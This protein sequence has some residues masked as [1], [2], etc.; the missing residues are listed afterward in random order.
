MPPGSHSNDLIV[1][2]DLGTTNSI[3]ALYQNGN[4][5]FFRDKS[6][7]NNAITVPSIINYSNAKP[8]VGGLAFT[9]EPSHNVYSIKRLMGKGR[10]DT[11]ALAKF[12]VADNTEEEGL[13]IL[14]N[15]IPKTPT[16]ISADILKYLKT[17]AENELGMKVN[18]AVITVPAYFDESARQATKDAAMIA[19]LQVIRLLSEPTAA[20]Y[21]YRLDSRAEGIYAV[22]DLGGGTFDISILRMYHGVLQ[23]I[24]V[25]GDPNLGGDDLDN[26]LM[27][28][29]LSKHEIQP[30]V[31]ITELNKILLE[32]RA[33]KEE[34]TD[35]HEVS[36]AFH[37]IGIII[38]RNELNET[39]KH[40][41]DRTIEI[42][43]NAIADAQIN[44]GDIEEIILVGGS[45]K[46][47]F[48]QE[49]IAKFAGKKPLNSIDPDLS[50]AIGAAMQAENLNQASGNLLLD[51]TP[52]SLG[53]ELADGTV[54]KIINRN[55]PIPVSKTYNFTS[56]KDL[57]T[58]FIIHVLQGESDQI[59]ECRSLGKFE[60]KGIP[61]LPAGQA[62]LEVTFQ[63][64]ADGLLIVKAK[65][66]TTGIAQEIVVKPSY[67]LTEKEILDMIKYRI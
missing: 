16:E 19:G 67:G 47:P 56:Q 54:E 45:T 49:K 60:L 51:V 33:I 13:R 18:K 37:G 46:S 7:N 57:Q 15:N 6:A 36:R 32:V 4:C 35:K 38:T 20:A 39:I 14:V 26:A 66:L 64:D 29:L 44:I 31:S 10:Q 43:S 24:A 25:G 58:G 3:I 61:L 22:Y 21:A 30:P 5:R 27:H 65:E 12:R 34:L 40:F 63:I 28:Y 50:V 48:I 42:F 9:M 53:I 8:V 41:I 59:S 1:G 23:V 17:L 11:N 52:L 2:I 55:T 62:K